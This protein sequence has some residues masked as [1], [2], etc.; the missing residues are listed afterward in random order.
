MMSATRA[1]GGDALHDHPSAQVAVGDDA[2]KL[3]VVHE[4]HRGDVRLV[5]SRRHLAHGRERGEAHRRA[6]DD[7]AE[8]CRHQVRRADAA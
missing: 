3:P 6:G 2:D 5:H 1:L 7:V 4:Q 8:T